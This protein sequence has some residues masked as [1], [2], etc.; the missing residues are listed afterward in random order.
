MGF[1]Q[2][3]G[4]KSLSKGLE[5]SAKGLTDGVKK[6]LLHKKL[7]AE[8]C[9]A[10]EE[11][12]I[13]A[14]LG[15]PLAAEFVDDLRRE[16][17]DQDITEDEVKNHL[18]QTLSAKL[19]GIAQ[20]LNITAEHK[21]YVL[22]MVGVN[23]SGKTTT[24]GKLSKMLQVQGKSV[25]LAAADTY[26]AAAVEQLDV[27]AQHTNTPIVKPEKEGADPASL[28]FKAYDQAKEQGVDVL[29]CDTAG[30]LQNRQDLM[31]QLEKMIRVLRKQDET[32]PHASLLVLDATVG[33]N[34]HQQV[35]A[36]KEVAQVSGLV[37]TKLD[38]T[39]KG[40]VIIALA[41]RFK[42]PIHFIGIGEKVEDLAPFEASDFAQ[43]ILKS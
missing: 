15:A 23:G 40:G 30:R 6:A 33:Q 41:D 17:F 28:I 36:F 19:D 9:D 26:R 31:A 7:D 29:I 16:K 27:W 21:P 34:A 42:L 38:T 13:M 32:A 18:A 20:P 37:M 2:K 35:E 11:A 25:L 8:T 1:F 14:D 24:I 5:K 10:L 3:L 43:A 4:L 39:A 22:F 12:L